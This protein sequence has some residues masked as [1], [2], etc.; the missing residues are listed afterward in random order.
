MIPEAVTLTT[1]ALAMGTYGRMAG[2]IEAGM[3]RD[4][5]NSGLGEDLDHGALL[6]FRVILGAAVTAVHALAY[7]WFLHLDDRAAWGTVGLHALRLIAMGWA[8]FTILHRLS[9][10][11]AREK[12]W[13]YCAPGNVY[14]RAYLLIT[15]GNVKA[16]GVTMYVVEALVAAVTITS[17][18]W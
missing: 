15:R 17:L 5:I 9:L 1:M 14:D 6:T 13:W 12:P 3:I 18:W 7:A 8:S 4:R 2:P 11:S 16:A 10:N